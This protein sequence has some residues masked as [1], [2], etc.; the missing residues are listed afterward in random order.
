LADSASAATFQIGHEPVIGLYAGN[1]LTNWVNGP[2][3]TLP[4]RP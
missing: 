4:V 3:W 1:A 2:L